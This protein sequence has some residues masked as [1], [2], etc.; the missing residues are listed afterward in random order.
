MLSVLFTVTIFCLTLYCATYE[1]S[2][3]K[4]AKY[5]KGR[6][7]VSSLLDTGIAVRI[8]KNLREA[9]HPFGISVEGYLFLHILLL[10]AGLIIVLFS[11]YTQGIKLL[12]LGIVPLNLY[13][14]FQK[15]QHRGR[16]QLELCR[17]Q[18][19]VYFQSSIGTPQDIILAYAAKVA[20]EPLKTPLSI[21]AEKYR[22]NKDLGKALEEFRQASDLMDFQAFTFILEQRERTGFSQENHQVQAAML[23][24]SKRMQRSIEREYKRFKLIIAAILVFA[25]YILFAA[26]P[27][28]KTVL[29]NINIVLR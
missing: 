26:V 4:D 23:K 6:R 29:N 11:G 1:Q 17:I 27:L 22:L 15:K 16:I 24:R 28:L 8:E 21:L 20:G 12:L 25:C 9:G 14:H 18:D 2:K 3:T 13:L 7:L 19:V 10:T 5:F